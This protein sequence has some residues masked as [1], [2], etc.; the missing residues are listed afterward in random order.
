MEI[1]HKEQMLEKLEMATARNEDI[2]RANRGDR[3]RDRAR[4]NRVCR[5]TRRSRSCSSAIATS[6]PSRASSFQKVRTKK[7]VPSASYMEQPLE[8]KIRGDFED[9]YSSS[10]MVEE[11]ERITRMPD[12]KIKKIEER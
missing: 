5:A 8:M 11:M 2:Q 6:P 10:F 12:L 3:R 4:S 7:P 9:F 1:D